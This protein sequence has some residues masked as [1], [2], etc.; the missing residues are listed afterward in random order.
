MTENEK[1]NLIDSIENVDNFTDEHFGTVL[2]YISDKDE[3]VRSRC[4]YM[5]GEF[6]LSDFRTEKS[7]ELLLEMCSDKDAFV[8]T[9]TYDSLSLFPDKRAESLLY[10]AVLN[11]PDEL[12]RGYAVLA[13]SDIVYCLHEK[14]GDDIKFLLDIIEK[15]KS[16]MC[17]LDCWYGLYRFGYEPA[18]FNMLDF[19]KSND[20]CIRCAVLNLLSD[21]MKTEDKDIIIY[22]V[23]ELIKTE[24][25]IAVRCDAEKLIALFAEKQ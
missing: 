2:K 15:E 23:D 9:E 8:R 13:W 18:L 20:Y 14:Y 10:K 1:V 6:M 21:I 19:L 12:A 3:L 16:E 17:R 4:V 22:E 7:M 25:T 24:K 11:E 5:L